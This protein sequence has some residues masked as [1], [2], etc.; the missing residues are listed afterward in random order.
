M[1]G[2]PQSPVFD[3]LVALNPWAEALWAGRLD[4][5]AASAWNINHP[6]YPGN[7]ATRDWLDSFHKARSDATLD[8]LMSNTHPEWNAE[9]YDVILPLLQNREFA[10]ARA[11]SPM[12]PTDGGALANRAD[13]LEG[14]T[15]GQFKADVLLLAQPGLHE[16]SLTQPLDISEL[17]FTIGP[18]I[19]VSDL[20]DI[21]AL[22]TRFGPYA[23]IV[24]SRFGR[25]DAAGAEFYDQIGFTPSSFSGDAIFTGATFHGGV[26]M[27]GVRFGGAADFTGAVFEGWTAFAGAL[28]EGEAIFRDTV[29]RDDT[30]FEGSVFQGGADFSGAVFERG[31]ATQG[32]TG[33]GVAEMIA[34]A[35]R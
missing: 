1:D 7:A 13:T 24:S 9:V 23:D 3:R 5:I 34:A 18:W 17:S 16:V 12:I 21:S 4:L 19:Y 2:T 29:F 11:G 8:R 32:I 30:T 6:N 20:P 33:E 27:Q 35:R 26:S 22:E 31:A 14:Y 28:F 10:I 15:I 25:F